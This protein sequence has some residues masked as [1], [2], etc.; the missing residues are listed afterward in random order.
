MSKTAIFFI[1]IIFLLAAAALFGGFSI[2][3]EDV[4]YPV[5][6]KVNLEDMASGFSRQEDISFAKTEVK[7]T[8]VFFVYPEPGFFT[9]N[10]FVKPS[11]IKYRHDM[12]EVAFDIGGYIVRGTEKKMYL[13]QARNAINEL[14]PN[15]R[16][17][18]LDKGVLAVVW[19][20]P[21]AKKIAFVSHKAFVE[22]TAPT[23]ADYGQ[24]RNKKFI[25]A[26]E[27]L[28]DFA[29]QFNP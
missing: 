27:F 4:L 2:F 20:I 15:G 1:S 28:I 18:I 25:T 9:A 13:E 26:E 29:R 16:E 11:E 21:A 14:L 7:K 22:M 24:N 8:A 5:G 6:I 17:I 19:D 10:I 3:K 12:V 23:K